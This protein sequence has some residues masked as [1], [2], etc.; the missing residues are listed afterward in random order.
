MS[1]Q[2]ARFV[3]RYSCV[4]RTGVCV[5]LLLPLPLAFST[6]ALCRKHCN[7]ILR[8]TKA[9]LSI[10]LDMSLL[11]EQAFVVEISSVRVEPNLQTFVVRWAETSP[12]DSG[13][14]AA[15]MKEMKERY[16]K[17]YF[18]RLLGFLC[19]ARDLVC[20]DSTQWARACVAA[21]A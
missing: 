2:H 7:E 14:D 19:H 11:P 1:A 16:S 15:E 12:H 5:T 21:P 8:S 17:L 6:Y 10:A 18:K 20:C 4:G 3:V 9:Q 13:E